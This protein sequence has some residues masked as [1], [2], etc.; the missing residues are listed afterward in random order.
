[1][2][3]ALDRARC[4]PAVHR[5]EH[6]VA[7]L[8][9]CEREADRLGIPHLPD[10]DHVGVGAQCVAQGS[11]EIGGVTAHLAAPDDGP[12]GRLE[13]VLDRVFERREHDRAASQGL[14]REGRQRRGLSGSG[15]AADE[16]E[17]IREESQ[18]VNRHGKA[19][20][21]ER[22]RR[23]REEADCRGE[24]VGGAI[25]VHA[26][27]ADVRNIA[28]EIDRSAR[29]E[30][31]LLLGIEGQDRRDVGGFV[32][33]EEPD[34]AVDAGA[35]R[36]AVGE[37]Q[38]A[39]ARM[40]AARA[41][42]AVRAEDGDGGGVGAETRGWIAGEVS[43]CDSTASAALGKGAVAVEAAVAVGRVAAFPPDDL[44][45]LLLLLR[46]RASNPF[47]RARSVTTKGPW[48]DS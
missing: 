25:G 29:R 37:V 47:S 22:R 13:R 18:I 11:R 35:R 45:A 46:N 5:R 30:R 10:E 42:R 8:R 9:R 33:V 1:M 16:D 17:A 6:Q 28:G 38:V 7:G 3:D 44:D 24:P 4:G 2:D 36:V 31:L 34:P 26:Y 15:R 39:R 21:G 23:A 27:A 48:G 40:A 41:T 20:R 43:G 14:L 12:R 19:Q 32:G